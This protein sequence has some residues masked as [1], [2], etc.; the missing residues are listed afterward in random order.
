MLGYALEEID[1]LCKRCRQFQKAHS[2]L[3]WA[4]ID[5]VE[6]GKPVPLVDDYD[7]T[8]DIRSAWEAIKLI[9]QWR[10]ENKLNIQLVDV[11]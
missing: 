11:T 6:T 7:T 1:R 5:L 4:Y 2:L 9:N 10:A 3:L 8:Q